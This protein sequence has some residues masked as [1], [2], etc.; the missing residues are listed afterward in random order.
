MTHSKVP[1]HF[2]FSAI[3]FLVSYEYF[4]DDIENA[5]KLGRSF[6]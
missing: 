3:Y 2:S 1:V 4:K 6:G 5:T